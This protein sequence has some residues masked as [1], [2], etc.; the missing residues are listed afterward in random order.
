[1]SAE[2]KATTLQEAKARAYTR[3]FKLGMLAALKFLRTGATVPELVRLAQTLVAST[4]PTRPTLVSLGL[5]LCQARE[6]ARQRQQDRRP[7]HAP[8]AQ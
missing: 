5:V 4:A 6:E 2:S 1:M 7:N 8:T 3:A